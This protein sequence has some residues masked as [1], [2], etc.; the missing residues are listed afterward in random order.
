MKAK[1]KKKKEP[2]Q[3]QP[4]TTTR[5]LD[6][7]GS[8]ASDRKSLAKNYKKKNPSMADEPKSQYVT[9]RMR[10][11]VQAGVQLRSNEE[12]IRKMAAYHNRMKNR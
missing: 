6:A 8:M 7:L 3:S 9:D 12:R 1:K 4:S 2:T 11:E 5:F 10:D